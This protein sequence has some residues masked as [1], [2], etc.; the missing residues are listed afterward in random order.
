MSL[1]PPT[2]F[3]HIPQVLG[4]QKYTPS[5][6]NN[7][8]YHKYTD[9]KT[10]YGSKTY[11]Q[12]TELLRAASLS[13]LDNM[14][15]SNSITKCATHLQTATQLQTSLQS[16]LNSPQNGKH[17][18]KYNHSHN[19]HQYNRSSTSAN[20]YLPI[21]SPTCSQNHFYNSQQHSLPL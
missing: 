13:K 15:N 20:F 17:T 12:K 19:P 5:Q 8:Y 6:A 18:C 2:L 4:I 14:V 9:Q 16:V 7:I 11:P 1:Y 3:N 21:S 10:L